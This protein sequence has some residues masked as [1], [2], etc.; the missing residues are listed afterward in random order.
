MNNPL[1]KRLTPFRGRRLPRRNPQYAYGKTGFRPPKKWWTKMITDARSGYKRIPGMT[2]KEYNAA[3]SQIVGGI[4]SKF[5]QETREKILRRYE[6]MAARA[7][8]LNPR[9]K[10]SVPEKHQLIIAKRTL[11]MPDAMVDVMG[12]PNKAQAREIIKELTGRTPRGNPPGS[13]HVDRL[14]RLVRLQATASTDSAYK[15]ATSKLEGERV[16]L[17]AE[18]LTD[19][20]INK[21]ERET[22]FLTP[23]DNPRRRSRR[24]IKTN[25]LP[26][27][28]LGVGIY[29]LLRRK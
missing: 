25:L 15:D 7:K 3:L 20:Q 18:G 14:Q 26:L 10:L 5:D 16:A 13:W 9:R 29:Y 28:I 19:T 27:A 17:R 6:P 1:R 22:E 8:G 23:K 12:G 11:Q 2:E 21:L 24:V 4:W